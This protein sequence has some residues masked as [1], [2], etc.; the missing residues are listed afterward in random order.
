MTYCKKI[1]ILAFDDLQNDTDKDYDSFHAKLDLARSELVRVLRNK[2]PTNSG[3]YNQ[4]IKK[5]RQA[6]YDVYKSHLP[7]TTEKRFLEALKSDGYT[8]QRR[9]KVGE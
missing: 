7:L 9:K 5:F 2:L 1:A 6:W 4:A 3:A 8:S